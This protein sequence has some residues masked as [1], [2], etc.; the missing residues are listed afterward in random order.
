MSSE[1]KYKD[2]SWLREQ[3]VNENQS[4]YDIAETCGCSDTT[5]RRWL[6]RHDIETRDSGQRITPRAAD[7]RLADR[8]WLYEKYVGEDESSKEIAERCNCAEE[9]VFRWLHE[10]DIRQRGDIGGGENQAADERL[11]D[12]EWLR[13]QYEGELKSCKEIAEIIG[14]C[15]NTVRDWLDRHSI[16]RKPN[17]RRI[18]DQRLHDAEWLREQYVDRDHVAADIAD[19]CGCSRGTVSKWLNRHGIETRD[20]GD[21]SG[22]IGDENGRWS[23][24]Q[25]PYGRGWNEVKRR[26]VRDRDDHVC[27]EPGCSISQTEHLS[28]YGE[29]L[30]VHHL[31]KA[32]EI[33]DPNKRNAKENLITLCRDCH[34]HWEKIADTGLVPEV[35]T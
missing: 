32:R 16:N 28:E 2:K 17:K 35:E 11:T 10:H 23:G 7:K 15:Q 29:K 1:P 25:T 6:D 20:P 14:C 30:H 19:E 26:E 27:Q 21:W 8:S 31:K 33:D 4:T 18:S 13:D 12:S 9:T 22:P 3:Y 24:G 34:R 5:I